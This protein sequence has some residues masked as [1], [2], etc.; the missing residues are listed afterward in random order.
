MREILIL[1]GEA[2]GDLHGALLAERLQ[3]LRPGGPLSGT[4]GARMRKSGVAMLEE[5]EGVVGFV[6]VLRHIPAH[7]RLYRRL[8]AR[9][10]SGTVGLV[11]CIDYPGFNLRVAAAAR[12]AGVPVLYYITPQVW[13]WRAGRLRTMARVIT[14]A[15]VILPFEEALLRG[16]GIDA[17]FVGHPL[18]DRAQ[19][20]RDRTTARA[21]LRL[22]ARGEILALFP[23]SRAQEIRRHL[24][25]FLAVAEEL[26]RRRS[27]LTVVLSVAPTIDLRDDEVPVPL[28][29]SASFDVLRAA[30]VALCKSGTT[31][32]E[33][34]VAGCPC[35]IVYR[36]SALSYAI[37]RRLV[38][39]DHIGL[40]N[41]VAGRTVA[42]EFVQHAFQPA[43]VADALDPLFAESS[44]ARRAMLEGLAEV[45]ERLGT[46]GAS[47]RV[48]VMAAAMAT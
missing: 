42:P 11:V 38:R 10:A 27:G 13:A 37:A 43:A 44:P 21:M 9:L 34:A 17:T 25:D 20:L 19:A 15:A 41:I 40:L 32:L 3:A 31:T 28:V 29:R 7:W 4:G 30:D 46:P 12:A 1:A 14:K 18:L 6:E 35:A 22:P 26:K 47:S 45:C 23:G 5:H 33:A 36:T 8:K 16:A 39:I 48:A 2:S 24:A